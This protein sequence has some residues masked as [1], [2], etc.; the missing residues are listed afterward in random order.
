MTSSGGT[1]RIATGKGKADILFGYS[2]I[3]LSWWVKKFKGLEFFEDLT[4]LLFDLLADFYFIKRDLLLDYDF[5]VESEPI[6]ETYRK[7]IMN[8]LGIKQFIIYI[9]LKSP[10]GLI[11]DR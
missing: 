8:L 6:I 5:V 4:V 1:L 2:V 3:L 11:P 10:F 7:R 9:I